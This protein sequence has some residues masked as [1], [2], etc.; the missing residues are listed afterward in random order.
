VMPP[1]IALLLT[2]RSPPLAPRSRAL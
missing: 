2:R 1:N